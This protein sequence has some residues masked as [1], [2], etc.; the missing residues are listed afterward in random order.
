VDEN[1][2]FTASDFIDWP[3][4]G[5]SAAKAGARALLVL[6]MEACERMLSH[7]KEYALAE[8]CERVRLLAQSR[9]DSCGD[10]KQIAALLLLGG[11][12]DEDCAKCLQK[13][14]AEGFSTFMSYYILSAMVKCA[15]AEETLAALKTYYGAMLDLGATTFW[16]D[17]D[18][19]WVENACRIDEICDGTKTDVHG[20]NGKYCYKGFRHS[21]C[22]GWASGPVAFLTE[23]VLGIDIVGEGCSKITITPHLG[24]LS[25]AKG[26]IATPCGKVTVAHTRNADGSVATHVEAPDGVE[27]VLC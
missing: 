26:S 22:H 19:A 12:A 8:E 2:C 21:L 3:S 10:L 6:C 27:I 24:D 20:D 7:L 16:E 23:Y 9:K 17:F 18:M 1:G 11:I 13:G 14:G 4:K 15:S 5:F 25:Y